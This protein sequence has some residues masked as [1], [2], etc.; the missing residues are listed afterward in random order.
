VL[1]RGVGRTRLDEPFLFFGTNSNDDFV[2]RKG[3]E[4]IADG[5]TD[6]RSPAIGMFD[7]ADDEDVPAHEGNVPRGRIELGDEKGA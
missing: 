1:G 5:E 7:G 3:G 2:R 4:S 6:V